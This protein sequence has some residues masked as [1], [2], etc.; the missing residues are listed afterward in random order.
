MFLLLQNIK[1]GGVNATFN[2]LELFKR[3]D[4]CAELMERRRLAVAAAAA[5]AAKSRKVRPLLKQHGV[6]RYHG[7]PACGVTSAIMA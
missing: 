2:Q 7:V 6:S 5:V 3:V 1:I 4:A